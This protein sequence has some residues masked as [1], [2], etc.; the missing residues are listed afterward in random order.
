MLVSVTGGVLVAE[1]DLYG[2]LRRA[3]AGPGGLSLG[4]VDAS[5]SQVA[6]PARAERSSARVAD[7][8]A[9]SVGQVEAALLTGHQDRGAAV[10]LGFGV[11]CEEA[12]L[13]SLAL[14]AEPGLG[15]EALHV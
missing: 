10:G 8:L 4:A 11:T 6:H 7:A 5:V 2:P 3:D 14:L 13:A 9:A 1:V 12:D 15:L